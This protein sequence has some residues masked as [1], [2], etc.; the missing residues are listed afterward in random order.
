MSREGMPRVGSGQGTKSRMHGEG[1]TE[2]PGGTWLGRDD[3][4]SRSAWALGGGSPS[5]GSTMTSARIPPQSHLRG[6]AQILT[7][8]LQLRDR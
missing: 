4:S 5:G 3:G 2:G 8:G 1:R 6:S 7:P